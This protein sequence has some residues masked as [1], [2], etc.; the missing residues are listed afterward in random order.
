MACPVPDRAAGVPALSGTLAVRL[1]PNSLI[2]RILGE[3][4]ITE[5]YTCNYELNPDLQDQL[6]SKGLCIAGVDETGAVRAVELPDHRFFV[7]TFF[8]PQHK[9][10]AERP[11]PL[12]TAF[13]QAAAE[14]AMERAPS[15]A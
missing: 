10:T 9:S 13:L 14:H 5:L 4:V 15:R 3:P 2:G 7:A 11:H 12:I 1:T 6:V 8:L